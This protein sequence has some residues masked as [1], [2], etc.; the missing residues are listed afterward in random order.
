[1]IGEDFKDH[2]EANTPSATGGFFM[3]RAPARVT[4]SYVVQRLISKTDSEMGT[5]RARY[6]FDIYAVDPDGLGK[7]KVIADELTTAIRSFQTSAHD[8]YFA[9]YRAVEMEVYNPDVNY[10]RVMLDAIIYFDERK[11]FS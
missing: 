9:S 5:M 6:Q 1:M 2:C 8:D 10:H 3:N 11:I 7:V 4:D